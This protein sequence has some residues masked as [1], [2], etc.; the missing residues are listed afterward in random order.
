M[1]SKEQFLTIKRLKQEGVPIAA[2]ARR[3]GI[4]EPT[5]RKWANM[6][7]AGFDELKKDDIPYLDNYREFILS[8]LRVCPQITSLREESPPGYEAQIDFGQ[9][10]MKDMYGKPVRVY[11]FCMVLAYSRMH[12]VYFSRDPF[13]TKT[14]IQAHEYAFQ[15]F[16]GRTQMI[17]YDQDRVFV[18]DENFGNIV[19]VPKFE[20]YVKKVGFS[21]RLCRPHDPQ[22]KGKVE[23]FVRY[24]KESFLAGRIYKGIDSLNS[25]A[26]RWLDA[27]GNGTTNLRTR[28]P[29]RVMFREEAQHLTRVQFSDE[30]FSEIRSVSDKYTVK[31]DWS[32]YE[33]PRTA[34]KPF[35]QVR[36]EEQDGMLLFYKA[37]ENELIHK[38]PRRQSPGGTT[39]YEGNSRKGD[40]VASNSFRLRFEAYDVAERFA[41]IVEETEPRYKNLQFGRMLTLSNVFTME[42]MIEAMDYC[43]YIGIC[44]AA[45]VTAFLIYRHGKDYVT[46]RISKNAYYRNRE[47]AEEIR[48][49]QDGRYR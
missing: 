27:E 12:Y 8:I 38:C 20:E 31:I 32:V 39:S 44:S 34:V 37:A 10:R 46:K 36:V 49:E 15:Y 7:E 19:L 13:T 28:K 41:E 22:S 9:Y 14:A 35:E 17:V 4:S 42:Q 26:L 23:T 6:S 2:I 33:L 3:I 30:G 40:S 47:R 25:D 16:G 45:E 21:V 1:I 48:R 11:F 18:V 43:V 29:P 24:I 5:T